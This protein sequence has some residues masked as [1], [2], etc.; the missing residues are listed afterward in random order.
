MLLFAPF[1]LS[2]L[3]LPVALVRASDQSAEGRALLVP[4]LASPHLLTRVPSASC[5]QVSRCAVRWSTETLEPLAALLAP[6]HLSGLRLPVALVR[7]G[8]R[9]NEGRALPM[10]SV[11]YLR[12]LGLVQ[13]GNLV[14]VPRCVA[15]QS[16]ERL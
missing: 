11:A 8:P 6:S 10:P 4:S 9:S 2:A 7:A 5:A 13:L 15:H 3:R 14:P 12:V 1:H 16:S